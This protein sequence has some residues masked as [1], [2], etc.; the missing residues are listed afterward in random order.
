MFRFWLQYRIKLGK[1]VGSEYQSPP[2]RQL[3]AFAEYDH[4][5][6]DIDESDFNGQVTND[7]PE[8]DTGRV[9]LK[10]QF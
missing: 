5:N 7:G 1:A 2:P 6:V 3:T 8:F 10:Y 9:G 4:Y